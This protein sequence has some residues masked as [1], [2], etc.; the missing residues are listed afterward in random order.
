M[1]KGQGPRAVVLWVLRRVAKSLLFF[2]WRFGASKNRKKTIALERQRVAKVTSR[3]LRRE[4]S[5]LEGSLYSKKVRPIDSKTVHKGSRHA[6]GP[7]A[8]RIYIIYLICLPRGSIGVNCFVFSVS[9]FQCSF[10][11]PFL[12][13]FMIV[14]A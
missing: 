7:K 12:Y 10:C 13:R 11:M 3:I 6:V 14:E 9:T 8:R 1:P 4:V 5:G 2:S